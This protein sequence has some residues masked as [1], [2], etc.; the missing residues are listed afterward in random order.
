VYYY[1]KNTNQFFYINRKT[2]RV[3]GFGI[4][5]PDVAWRRCI[6]KFSASE[7][8]QIKLGM[9]A[10]KTFGENFIRPA[11]QEASMAQ[12]ATAQYEAA[13]PNY[14]INR[15]SFE[16]GAPDFDRFP[17]IESRF[18]CG[19][20]PKD[21]QVKYGNK[22]SARCAKVDAHLTGFYRNETKEFWSINY[23]TKKV[24]HFGY[25]ESA[26]F[27]ACEDLP[28]I[29]H[30][31]LREEA[32]ARKPGNPPFPLK[33]SSKILRIKGIALGESA[34]ACSE[35]ASEIFS[36][37]RKIINICKLKDGDNTT[38]VYFDAKKQHVVKIVRTVYVN[39]IDSFIN[40]ALEFYGKE[41]FQRK[42]EIDYDFSRA[43]TYEYGDTE[44]TR[45]LKI[46]ISKCMIRYDGRTM[47]ICV[48]D[49]KY[50]VTFLMVDVR[51]FNEAENEGRAAF[52]K[53]EF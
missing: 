43:E 30:G 41:I 3:E 36:T 6:R 35:R 8:A 53:R 24:D 38:L 44:K 1:V 12:G 27:V 14:S 49:A 46:E 52:K 51:A 7:I 23:F 29:V 13:D 42:K 32:E 26:P 31:R 21:L 20:T 11:L 48:D 25:D 22:I 39:E 16:C 18:D 40:D 33:A 5:L 45:G 4:A 9:N 2:Q 17:K 47:N 28:Q 15:I 19:L 10:Q 50:F 37:E 34:A